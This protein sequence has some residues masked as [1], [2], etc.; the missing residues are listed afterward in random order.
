MLIE[1]V[2]TVERVGFPA[3]VALILM[4]VLVYVVREFLA[5]VK[6]SGIEHKAERKEWSESNQ[7]V[8][9]D[10]TGAIKDLEQTIRDRR[11]V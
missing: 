9:K 8:Q 5:E 2:E 4:A 6:R 11:S 1:T 7:A 10:L 3:A